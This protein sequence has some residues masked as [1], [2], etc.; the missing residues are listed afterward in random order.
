M[1]ISLI[2][3]KQ[4]LVE[5]VDMVLKVHLSSNMEVLLDPISKICTRIS[6]LLSN[7][8]VISS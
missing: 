5:L 7:K 4:E 3:S 8:R 2:R 1:L 6:Q